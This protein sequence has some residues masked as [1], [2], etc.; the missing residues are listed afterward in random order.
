M[1]TIRSR[2]A[3][4]NSKKW[5]NKCSTKDY[6]NPVHLL[7]RILINCK[8]N[9]LWKINRN[10]SKNRRFLGNR[11]RRSKCLNSCY[12]AKILK[13]LTIYWTNQGHKYS[14]NLATLL[15]KY[16]CKKQSHHSWMMT[17]CNSK[18]STYNLKTRNR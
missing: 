1:W 3:K 9:S 17:T 7:K 16:S 18:W 4:N 14:D 2:N 8:T 6:R 13:N 10:C 12:K 5:T 15:M 11:S